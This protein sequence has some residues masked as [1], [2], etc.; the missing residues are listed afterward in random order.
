MIQIKPSANLSWTPCYVNFMCANLEVPLD[1]EDSQAG[2]TNIAFIKKASLNESAEDI[3]INPGGPSN[4]GIDFVLKG[5]SLLENLFGAEYNLIGFD[6]RGVNNSGP[7]LTC[8]PSSEAAQLVFGRTLGLP[9]DSNSTTSIAEAYELAG[10]WSQ[11]C[12]KANRD[13]HAK[14]ANTPAVSADLLRFIESRSVGRGASADDAKLWFYGLSYG[15]VIG[16]T[17][18]SLYPDRVGR[19]ILDAPMDVEDYYSGASR[20]NLND[21]DAAVRS[22]FKFCHE[23]G[24]EGCA[25]HA[26]SPEAIETRFRN[27][28]LSI[29]EDPIV[30]VDPYFVQMPTLATYKTL[31]SFVLQ[32]TFAP[33]TRFPAFAQLMLGVEKRNGSALAKNSGFGTLATECPGETPARE[34]H[35]EEPRLII[36]CNDANGRTNLSSMDAFAE[37]ME[38]M[39]EQSFYL[40]ESWAGAT[41]G[42]NCRNLDIR[43]PKSQQFSLPSANDTIKTSPIL[44]LSNTIDPTSPLKGAQKM[45]TSFPGSSLLIVNGVGHGTITAPS[46]CARDYVQRYLDSGA[47]PE[48]GEVCIPDGVPF[49]GSDGGWGKVLKTVY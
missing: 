33:I 11:W 36:A 37:S 14:Y 35:M 2:T 23:A 17:F 26:E 45:T 38:Y 8:F 15:T 12:S 47:L 31:Q 29:K 21:A 27:A 48:S 4:S 3:L 13:T 9:I 49:K 19:M 5:A 18:A 1:Y 6:P 39:V 16:S 40:G 10:G 32:A 43:S 7:T 20:E 30:V 44:F 25:F 22:F 42:L 46:K 28:L 34:Y 24:K 41:V